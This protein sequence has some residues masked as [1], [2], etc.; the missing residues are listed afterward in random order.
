MNKRTFAL[1]LFMIISFTAI[2]A[3]AQTADPEGA[4]IIWN[5]TETKTASAA[6][7]INTSGG[8]F[9]T[10]VIYGETQDPRWKAYVGNVT[11]RMTLDDADNYTI[12]DWSI[13]TVSGEVYASRNDSITWDSIQCAQ[14]SDITAEETLMNHTTTAQDSIN[15]TFWNSVHKEFYVGTRKIQNSTC[16]A[17]ATWVNDTAQ[18]PSEEALFQ[19]VLLTDTNSLVYTTILHDSVHGFNFQDYDFQMIVAEKD[20]P[21]T[22]ATPYYFWVEIS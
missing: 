20:L 22:Q 3:L 11:G 15:S 13:T 19:E 4:S 2:S 10:M 21:G 6:S 1:V 16:R 9:T 18:A 12:Y 14:E 7:F 17:I 5:E 8:S